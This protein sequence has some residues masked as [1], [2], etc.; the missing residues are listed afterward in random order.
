MAPGLLWLTVLMIVPCLLIFVLIFFERGT[1]G[2]I[3]WSVTTLGNFTRAFDPFTCQSCSTAP[4]SRSS[5][6][7]LPCSSA[8]PR[9]TQS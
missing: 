7:S 5:P 2:G 8:I 6:R 1:Y 4:A 3:D 9:P